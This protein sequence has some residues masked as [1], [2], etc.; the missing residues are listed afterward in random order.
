MQFPASWIENRVITSSAFFSS[1]FLRFS[2]DSCVFIFQ[3]IGRVA[4][5]NLKMH[6]GPMY[7]FVISDFHLKYDNGLNVLETSSMIQCA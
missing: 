6:L 1:D 7:V 4:L 3:Q 2:K 5:S